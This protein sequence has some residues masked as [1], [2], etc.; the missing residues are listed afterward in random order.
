MVA[1]SKP[2]GR[3]R[4]CPSTQRTSA[5]RPLTH[6]LRDTALRKLCLGQPGLG[7]N[8]SARRC[9]IKCRRGRLRDPFRASFR[10]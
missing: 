7:G 10:I 9:S 1:R 5:G 6:S 4:P 3:V 8:T 2:Y